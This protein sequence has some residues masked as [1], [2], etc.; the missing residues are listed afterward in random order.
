RILQL[1]P[2][3]EMASGHY[4]PYSAMSAMAI[5]PIYIRVQDVAEFIANGGEG[6]L[7]EDDRAR[8]A[9]ARAAEKVE[10]ATLRPVKHRA[11]C[12]AFERFIEEEWPGDSA[13]AEDFRSYCSTESWWLEDYALFRAI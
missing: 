1:L 8:L 9:H 10:Y 13:R 4:S 11:L 3:N 12:A 2:L 5:D 7:D 6:S